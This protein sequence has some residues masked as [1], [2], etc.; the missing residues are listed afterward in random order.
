MGKGMPPTSNPID[1]PTE[2]ETCGAELCVL[3]LGYDLG[4]SNPKKNIGY[5]LGLTEYP[6]LVIGYNL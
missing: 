6:S 4:D 2:E 3:S 1:T 5:N